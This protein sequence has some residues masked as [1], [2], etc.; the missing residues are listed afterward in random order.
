MGIIEHDGRDLTVTIRKKL[1]SG[2]LPREF[3]TQMWVGYGNGRPCDACEQPV[4]LADVE[5]EP[6]FSDPSVHIRLHE[7]CLGVWH[8][9][10]EGSR[11]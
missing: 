7:K 8:E 2:R 11:V 4:T 3:P 1:A 10:R 9:E 5:Y 6:E